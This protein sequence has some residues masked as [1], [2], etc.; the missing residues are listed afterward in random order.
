MTEPEIPNGETWATHQHVIMAI[1][2]KRMNDFEPVA[3]AT[4]VFYGST[5][6]FI[7][8]GPREPGQPITITGTDMKTYMAGNN[9]YYNIK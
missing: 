2:I 8:T 4:P 6:P 7:I 9:I 3:N 1:N 5:S